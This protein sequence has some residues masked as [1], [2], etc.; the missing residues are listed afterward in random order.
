MSLVRRGARDPIPPPPP[1]HIA[2]RFIAPPSPPCKS[3]RMALVDTAIWPRGSD[4][5]DISAGNRA[6]STSPAEKRSVLNRNHVTYMTQIVTCVFMG[7][8]IQV[9][10]RFFAVNPF[11]GNCANLLDYCGPN[12]GRVYMVAFLLP[13]VKVLDDTAD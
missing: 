4:Q 11:F 1:P 10:P 12:F 7:A 2:S 5:R 8:A 6:Q 3:C 13:S 9:N